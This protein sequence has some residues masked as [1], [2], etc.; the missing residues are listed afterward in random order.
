MYIAAIDTLPASSDPEFP[1]RAAVVLTG[2]RK[3]QATMSQAAKRSR[4]SPSV[5]VALSDVRRR[6][7]DLMTIAA[8]GP[9]GTLGQ[10]LYVARN[11]AKLS[12][13]EA[14][15]GMGL[16]KDLIESIEAEGPADESETAQIKEL[17]AA[18][19]G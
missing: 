14:A 1:E 11:R 5:I 7:D 15:N 13:Q 2:M 12:P 8:E 9:G 19:G 4:V 10:R 17:I 18:L 6:Y 3:L 16:R